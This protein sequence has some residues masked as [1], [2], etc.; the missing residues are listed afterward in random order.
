MKIFIKKWILGK[1]SVMKSG[2]VYIPDRGDL[3]W[4]CFD[5][6]AGYEQKGTRPAIVISPK[7]Y[8]E[9]SSLCLCFP[10]TSKQKGYPFE[11]VLPDTL[12]VKGVVLSDQM[13]SLDFRVRQAKFITQTPKSVIAEIQKKVGLLIN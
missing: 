13:R 3:I 10:I 11:V 4:L 2:E 1:E 12:P 7:I 6:Q 8:N 9:K 5:P